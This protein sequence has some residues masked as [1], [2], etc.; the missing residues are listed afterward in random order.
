MHSTSLTLRTVNDFDVDAAITDV[1]MTTWHSHAED[2]AQLD[3]HWAAWIKWQVQTAVMFC[4]VKHSDSSVWQSTVNMRVFCLSQPHWPIPSVQQIHTSVFISKHDNV[5]SAYIHRPLRWLH[6][7]WL[8]GFHPSDTA[9]LSTGQSWTELLESNE[10]L[11]ITWHSTT[12]CLKQFSKS[13]SLTVFKSWLKTFPFD[14]V[15]PY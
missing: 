8:I 6:P 9:M 3:R 7:L 12:S 10:S 13:P 1:H 11:C 5:C 2:W 4:H 15:F 14:K